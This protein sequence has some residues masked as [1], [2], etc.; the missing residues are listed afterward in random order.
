MSPTPSDP[1]QS[2]QGKMPDEPKKTLARQVFDYAVLA[3]PA[4]LIATTSAIAPWLQSRSELRIVNPYHQAQF[5]S[6]TWLFTTPTFLF[7]IFWAY[8]WSLTKIRYHLA[9]L[10][11]PLLCV[12]FGICKYYYN[13]VG[14][15]IIPDETTDQDISF[16][17]W[18]AYQLIFVSLIAIVTLGAIYL[19]NRGHSGRPP[20]AKEG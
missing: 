11:A 3:L 10:W 16:R 8:N 4:L 7:V 2:P 9:Y 1:A 12:S 15:S 20:A 13:T 17:W 14:H 19:K 5:D 18:I 6:P